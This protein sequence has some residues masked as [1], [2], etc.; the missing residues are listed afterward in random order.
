[1]RATL[2]E[3]IIMKL[4]LAWERLR[5]VDFI[6]SA[7]LDRIGL[8]PD[9]SSRYSSSADHYLDAVLRTLDVRAA[10]DRIV[11]L[12]CGKGA[13]LSRMARFPFAGVEG[14]ELS[15][16]LV[17]IARSNMARLGLDRVTVHEGDA[18]A[19]VD[20]DRFRFFYLYNPF[21][22]TVMV[23]VMNNI[24]ASLARA[25]REAVIVY[26]NPVCHEA[27]VQSGNFRQVADFPTNENFPIRVYRSERP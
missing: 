10:T 6:A 9:R 11:D 22:C 26:R 21:P 5:G 4:R 17:A 20:V 23:E 13:A 25:P 7:S 16:G 14:V 24:H 15:A 12:G 18:G 2:H 8:T 3:R 27:V 19:F 1:M